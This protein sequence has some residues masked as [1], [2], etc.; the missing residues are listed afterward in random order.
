[1]I[2]MVKYFLKASLERNRIINIIYL[3]D[4]EITERSIRVYEISNGNIKA[5]CFLRN[6]N[7]VFK[8][9]NILSAS[10]KHNDYM[11]AK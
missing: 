2:Y 3:K 8:I 9:D 1:M 10:F 7:R 11:L 5:F 4:T 6:Q